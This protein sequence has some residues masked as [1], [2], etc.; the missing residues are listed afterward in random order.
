MIGQYTPYAL[1][2]QNGM[3]QKAGVDVTITEGKGSAQSAR[4]IGNGEFPMGA[5]DSATTAVAIAKGV[6]VT[7]VATFLG[8]SPNAVLTWQSEGITTPQQLV[9]KTIAADAEGS[10]YTLWP[11]FLKAN[12]LT[13]DQ[14]K[15]S[16]AAG[17]AKV[18]LMSQNKITG[19]LG[20]I[21]DE[22]QDLAEENPG[23]PINQMLYY[24]WG[25]PVVGPGAL[26]VNNA[27]LKAQP[28][29]VAAVVHASQ[30]A[31]DEASKNPE[32]A[33]AAGAALF[34]TSKESV[35]LGQWKKTITLR[36]T[37]YN[38]G[39]SW[40]YSATPDWES[41][42]KLIK[43]YLNPQASTDVSHYVTN[44]FIR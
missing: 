40:G 9:G 3:F 43:Q 10:L 20:L 41:S 22:A 36:Y 44:R 23:R 37:K 5:I 24:D 7:I 13:A 27:F 29:V 42:L 17:H 8:K 31:W 12:H 26:V 38:Q 34:S 32:A 28:N 1:A 18:A 19:I 6:P 14:V 25:V 16:I 11:A 35:L 39:R 30:Q 21:N 2:V 15:L 33:A 4:L